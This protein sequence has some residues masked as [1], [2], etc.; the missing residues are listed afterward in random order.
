[1]FCLK[2]KQII[3]DDE[4]EETET[5]IVYFYRETKTLTT[6]KSAGGGGDRGGWVGG[7]TE[8]FQNDTAQR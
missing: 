6:D 4:I 2:S 5:N 8:R 7:G 3:E 1:M